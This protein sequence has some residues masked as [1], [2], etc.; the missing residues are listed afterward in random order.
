L[1][2]IAAKSISGILLSA[3]E[4]EERTGR[5]AKRVRIVKRFMPGR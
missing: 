5:P 3:D 1:R 4:V 2:A